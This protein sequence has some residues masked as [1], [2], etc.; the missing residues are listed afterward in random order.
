MR[1]ASL[2][3]V[4]SVLAVAGGVFGV[5]FAISNTCRIESRDILVGYDENVRYGGL[6]VLCPLDET[7]FPPEIVAPTFRWEDSNADSDTWIVT[8]R[9]RDDPE[10]LSFCTDATEWT[11]SDEH[12]KTIKQRSRETKAT[13]TVLG[14]NR[15]CP[16]QILS[17]TSISISTS[18][19]EVGA[20]LFYREVNLP[21]VEAVKD[22]SRIRWRFGPISLRRP[23]VVLQNLPVC[24]N[25]HSF[26]A[27]GDTLA[28]DVD[29]ANTK[30]SY[31]ITRL[32]KDMTLAT[33]DIITWDDYRK[34]DGEVTFGLL[35]QIS[36]DGRF[37]VSTVK[38]RSVFVATPGLQFSQLFFPIKG[39]LC[40][41]DRENKTFAALPGADDPEYVQSNPTWSP[42]GKSIVFARAKAYELAR[43]YTD[44]KL[45][46]RENQCDEFVKRGKPFRFDLYR[47][48]FNGGQGG[49][50]EPLEGASHNG[51]SNFFARYSPDG[52]WIVFCRAKNYMLLQPD[53]QLYIIPAEGGEARRLRCNTH[54]MNSWHSWSP[55]G[56]WLVFS[57][58]VNS[59]YT[60]L[61]LTHIDDQGRSTPPVVLSH[62]T[63]PQR[64]ANIP[65]FVNASPSAIEKIHEQFLDD[66]SYIRAGREFYKADD[67]DSAIEEY[68]NA[69]QLNPNNLEAHMRLTILYSFK[70]MYEQGK[71]HHTR[72][73]ALC[74]VDPF[75]AHH[76]AIALMQEERYTEAAFCL[77]MVLRE[78]PPGVFDE[79]TLLSI[80]HNL[81]IALR[82]ENQF[83][84]SAAHLSEAVRLDPKHAGHH[85]ELALTLACQGKTGH[86]DGA[87]RHYRTAVAIDPD[88]DR[89]PRLH[90]VLAMRYAQAS[91]F[92]EAVSAAE[93][94]SELARARGEKELA[95][96]IEEELE[97]YRRNESP[98]RP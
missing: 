37:V 49:E 46:L 19:D 36:P 66:F 92:R 38:D 81:G 51:L 12:W 40:I 18:E 91:R 8:I 68:N 76:V 95:R 69:L 55:N 63:D 93:R 54:L 88:I 43:S 16:Q 15:L 90:H 86:L 71:T 78:T 10:R 31:V 60:Q 77:S 34:E 25:C 41:Y 9:F 42:D 44:N 24:G 82:Y 75:A 85:Y 11:P 56:R 74:A 79:E 4:S 39:I 64:A 57:S 5:W 29:Y 62:F 45:L 59:P 84:E 89:W 17:G 65:E 26:S 97:F 23:A 94:A 83:D 96:Q 53:S 32:A 61:C 67:F 13:V 50:P 87:V 28:M 52:K 47:I 6:T 70:E 58:K 30:G 14:V 35:S 21:F 27:S 2:Y 33:S 7:L 3:A 22:P 48:A 80:H 73:K 72:A 1:K 98:P 20:P